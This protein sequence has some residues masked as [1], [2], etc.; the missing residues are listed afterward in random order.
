M[1]TPKTKQKTEY[2]RFT[3]VARGSKKKN[4]DAAQRSRLLRI[5]M[6]ELA[7][8][9]GKS[10]AQAVESKNLEKFKELWNQSTSK[11][12]ARLEESFRKEE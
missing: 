4:G 11:V 5:V 6:P 1:K 8:S 9:H 3:M 10:L 2:T 7:G 12:Y